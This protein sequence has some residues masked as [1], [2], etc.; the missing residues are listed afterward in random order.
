MKPSVCVILISALFLSACRKKEKTEET[1]LDGIKNQDEVMAD[2]GGACTP[3]ESCSDGILNQDEEGIDCGGSSCQPC[4]TC[5]DG[6]MNSSETGVD[7][8]GA[9]GP[10][11]TNACGLPAGTG[12]IAYIPYF[13]GRDTLNQ[14]TASIYDPGNAS[15][16]KF[17]VS[18]SFKFR[19]SGPYD[20]CRGFYLR[21][22]GA[23]IIDMPYNRVQAFTTEN[24]ND[25]FDYQNPDYS[26]NKC[27]LSIYMPAYYLFIAP[28][29]KVFVTRLGENLYNVKFCN[30]PV[31]KTSNYT[32]NTNF[33]ANL[34][35]S[36][37]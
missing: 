18:A 3:C 28:G 30:L 25:V 22:Y 2:C 6:K 27:V 26:R 23:A 7:C 13:N 32:L 37:Q 21:F 8:G 34:N 9:C 10:C 16:I 14:Y 33:S 31:P 5:D 17:D 20:I 24:I 4:A 29:E 35:F 1:C 12:E 36:F 11:G 19:G 15:G